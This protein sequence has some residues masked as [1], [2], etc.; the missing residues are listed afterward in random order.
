MIYLLQIVNQNKTT[1]H[2]LKE[3]LIKLAGLNI[4]KGKKWD[5]AQ[6]KG[7]WVNYGSFQNQ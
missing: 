7:K 4:N 2:I 5:S 3:R 1:W 6:S